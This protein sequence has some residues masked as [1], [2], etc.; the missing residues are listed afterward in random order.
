MIT[1]LRYLHRLQH[2]HRRVFSSF[3][4]SNGEISA[5]DNSVTIG[6]VTV[7]EPPR[8]NA[9]HL[10]PPLPSRLNDN[11]V[12]ASLPPCHLSHLRWMMQK[13]LILKQDFLLLGVPDLARERYIYDPLVV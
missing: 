13:D 2:H 6:D 11:E 7:D 10:V 5:F 4:V 1:T 3:A 12:N 8:G 9:P